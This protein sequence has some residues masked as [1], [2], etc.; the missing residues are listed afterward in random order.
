VANQRSWTFA[1]VW[2]PAFAFRLLWTKEGLY[3][4]TCFQPDPENSR[5]LRH[6]S[7]PQND[8]IKTVGSLSFAFYHHPTPEDDK[9]WLSFAWRNSCCWWQGYHRDRP[10]VAKLYPLIPRIARMI[11]AAKWIKNSLKWSPVIATCALSIPGSTWTAHGINNRQADEA[12]SK[13]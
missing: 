7:H 8:G 12:H 6:Q 2:R 10:S 13:L 4:Q 1:V 3:R 11:L 5:P 9:W